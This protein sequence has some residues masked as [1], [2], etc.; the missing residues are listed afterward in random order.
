MLRCSLLMFVSLLW[1]VPTARAG[2]ELVVAVYPRRGMVETMERFAPLARHLGEALRRPVRVESAPDLKS[3]WEQ[4]V[5]RR[6][7]L[8][9]LNQYHYVKAHKLLGYEAIAMNVEFDS[10]RLAGM[11]VAR[12]GSE[13]NDLRALAGQTIVFAGGREAMQ[14]YIIPKYLLA[15]AGVSGYTERVA[16]TQSNA[17]KSVLLQQAAAAATGDSCLLQE[18]RD[19][20]KRLKILAKSAPLAHLPWAV[21]PDLTAAERAQLAKILYRVHQTAPDATAAARVSRLVP[22]RDADYDA[23]RRIVADVLQERY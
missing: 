2:D 15:Q 22:A 21:S 3:F 16:T 1:A 4:L 14:S 7:A 23:H 19:A 18:G 12:H 10:P 20:A 5:A 8:V 13:I 11:L 17:L 6:Y 9:H